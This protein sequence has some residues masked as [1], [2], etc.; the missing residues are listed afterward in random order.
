M[1]QGG[2]GGHDVES[3]RADQVNAQDIYGTPAAYDVYMFFFVYVHK[4][5]CIQ[6]HKC[7][8]THMCTY[9]FPFNVHANVSRNTVL[10]VSS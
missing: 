8:Y 9:T 2:P 3:T 6:S 7:I 5:L 1:I 10:K 4:N